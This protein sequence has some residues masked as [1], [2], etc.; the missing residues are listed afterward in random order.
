MVLMSDP[1]FIFRFTLMLKRILKDLDYSELPGITGNNLLA[2]QGTGTKEDL[3]SFSQKSAYIYTTSYVPYP[4]RHRVVYLLHYGAYLL[5]RPV[6]VVHPQTGRERA[7][8][9]HSTIRDDR[10]G[11]NPELILS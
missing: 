9:G 3:L 2:H 5:R 1:V 10:Q 8:A 4:C 6:S 11:I 7:P